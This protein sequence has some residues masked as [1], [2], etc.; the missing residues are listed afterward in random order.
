MKKIIS[1]IL[2]GMLIFAIVVLASAYVFLRFYVVPK[3][4]KIADELLQSEVIETDL[5]ATKD[6]WR[7][8]ERETLF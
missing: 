2:V 4:S 5:G 3:Y 6:S 1:R 7:G 8:K